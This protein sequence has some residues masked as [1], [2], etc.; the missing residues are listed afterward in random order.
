MVESLAN[1]L[2][3]ILELPDHQAEFVFLRGLVGDGFDLCFEFAE[4][5]FCITQPRFKLELCQKPVFVGVDQS[6]NTSFCLLNHR[7]K[8]LGLCN[9]LARFFVQSS[10][11]LLTDPIGI[12]QKGAYVFPHGGFQQVG[13]DLFVPADSFAAKT[14]GVSANTPVVGIVSLPAFGGGTT[15]RLSV[16]GVAATLALEQTLEEIASSTPSLTV[17]LFVF[18]KLLLNRLEQIFTD[19]RRNGDAFLLV[20]GNWVNRIVA[21]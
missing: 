11:I 3:E 4:T 2:R 16:V 1:S 12:S 17:A 15:Y 5:L 19:D 14:I 10:L 21:P 9:L 20:R 13:A 6:G 18:N 8:L 7:R